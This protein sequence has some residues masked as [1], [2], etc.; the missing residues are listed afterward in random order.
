[1][2]TYSLRA[3][4]GVVNSTVIGLSGASYAIDA[5]GTVTGVGFPD[6]SP[7]LGS[8][9]ALLPGFGAGG[10]AMAAQ[11][12]LYR[13]ISGGTNP[14]ATNADVV[15]AN[16]LLPAGTFDITGRGIAASAF[17]NFANNVNSKRVKLWIGATTV[18]VGGAI[19]GG[20]LIGDTGAFTTAAATQFQLDAQVFKYGNPGSNT[21]CTFGCQA[22]LGAT[23]GG[24]GAG[25][26]AVCQTLT[27]TESGGINVT[28]TGD[29]VTAATDIALFSFQVDALN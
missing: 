6:L 29:A 11:G 21:Q 26:S 16:F 18:A 12:N 5:T 2:T 1:M 20:T 7:L 4:P 19:S 9:Y 28:L 14:G 24:S 8:G 27:L 10:A 3:P 25:A 22:I 15:M 13:L 17:G 23:H